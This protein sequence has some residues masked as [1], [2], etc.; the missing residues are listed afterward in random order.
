M[1][2][3]HRRVMNI[4]RGVRYTGGMR[5]W[6]GLS[7]IGALSACVIP[8]QA[9]AAHLYL[10]PPGGVHGHTD[11]FSVPV[12]IDPQG[13]CI[14]AV[15]VRLAYDPAVLSVIDI[16]VGSSIIPLWTTRPTIERGPSG[17]TGLVVLEG[18]IP[19]GYCG[20][21]SGD[22][23]AADTLAELV[24]T[25][26]SRLEGN[27]EA[28]RASIVV[29][30][31]TV[32]YRNDGTGAAADLT[33]LGVDLDFVATSSSPANTWLEAVK[34]DTIAPELFDVTLVRGPSVGSAKHYIVF[35]TTDKQSGI[36]HYEIL[37][38]DPDRFGFLTWVPR[39][40]HWVRGESPYVL[41][42]Q[43][44]RSKILV[45]AVDKNGNERIV[46]Y[47]PPLSLLKVLTYPA[48]L[49]LLLALLVLLGGG[50]LGVVMW[51]RRVRAKRRQVTAGGSSEV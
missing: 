1:G 2:A 38:T 23:G 46:E 10:D 43:E 9:W 17:E 25:G 21:V 18:G 51:V 49:V 24:V 11:T 31:G 32:V 5:A 44:L 48:F 14:N 28:I 35:S 8:T 39:E 37:E 27:T 50:V 42:D 4:A 41:R 34:N 40:S 7:V 19:G 26:A 30:P 33:V 12:R 15:S 47:T 22:L 45:K 13:T 16:G 6:L 29:D 36:D 3:I 20:R